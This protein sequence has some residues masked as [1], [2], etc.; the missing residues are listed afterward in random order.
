MTRYVLAALTAGVLTAACV[1][2]PE[3]WTPDSANRQNDAVTAETTADLAMLPDSSLAD[4]FAKADSLPMD[5]SADEL[6]LVDEVVSVDATTS[7]LAELEVVAPQETIEDSNVQEITTWEYVHEDHGRGTLVALVETYSGDVLT[8]GFTMPTGQDSRG[9]LLRLDGETGGLSWATEN[10]ENKQTWFT[11]VVENPVGDIFLTTL[12][13]GLKT[14]APT[15]D[16]KYAQSPPDELLG[17]LW[18]H[19][20]FTSSGQL[21]IAGYVKQSTAD[22]DYAGKLC[23]LQQDGSIVWCE[24]YGPA[25]KDTTD[26]FHATVE[27]PS[28]DLFAVGSTSSAAD[29]NDA[30]LAGIAADGELLWDKTLVG[31]P[32]ELES[33]LYASKTS[34]GNIIAVGSVGAVSGDP[35]KYD[36]RIMKLDYA[37][38]TKWELKTDYGLADIAKKVIELPGGDF[39]MLVNCHGPDSTRFGRFLHI[40]SAGELLDTVDLILGKRLYVN[41]AVVS[42]DGGILLVGRYNATT[43]YNKE[44]PW[45]KKMALPW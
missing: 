20:D 32:G 3:P 28:G 39:L 42:A 36:S 12:N 18:E 31:P 14:A 9:L 45:V 29:G 2:Q 27:L 44:R 13:F 38:S 4:S 23:K 1:S 26:R 34:D 22:Q 5:A 43:D 33:F 17:M 37:G 30:W 24:E 8:A 19:L 25:V 35:E 21:L 6:P 40:S 15:G 10:P 41:D 11:D 16:I 7:D